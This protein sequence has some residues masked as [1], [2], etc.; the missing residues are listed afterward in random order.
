VA[1]G[2]EGGPVGDGQVGLVAEQARRLDTLREGRVGEG[3]LHDLAD[4]RDA[5]GPADEDDVV[6]VT[7]ADAGTLAGAAK[8]LVATL[9]GA[10]AALADEALEVGVLDG[11]FQRDAAAVL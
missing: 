8:G 9:D 4:E 11:Q 6:D 10:G 5:A 7:Q 1:G 3:V 2:A